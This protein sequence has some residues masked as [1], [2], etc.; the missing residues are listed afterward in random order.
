M[1]KKSKVETGEGG[2]RRLTR[3]MRQRRTSRRIIE[4]L[5]GH[6]DMASTGALNIAP[7]RS[8]ASLLC[9]L[10]LLLPRLLLLLVTLLLLPLQLLLLLVL[11]LPALH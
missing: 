7:T 5:K 9:L 4:E 8:A 10:Q 11:L 2:K 1:E 6:G 3:S